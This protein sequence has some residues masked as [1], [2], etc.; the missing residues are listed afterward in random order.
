MGR[1]T[2]LGYLPHLGKS[3]VSLDTGWMGNE[4]GDLLPGMVPSKSQR[5]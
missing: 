1:G 4:R 3:S 5:L 2:F